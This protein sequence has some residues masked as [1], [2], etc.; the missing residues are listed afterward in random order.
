M[1]ERMYA[2]RA[3]PLWIAGQRLLILHDTVEVLDPRTG[4]KHVL[5][6]VPA[7]S[8]GIASS[9]G[10]RV[11]I[12]G[13]GGEL[14]VLD[15]ATLAFTPMWAGHRV[16][17]IQ[18][19]PDGS[20]LAAGDGER[21]VVLDAAGKQ[22][23]ERAGG[24]NM[25]ASTQDRLALFDAKA[26]HVLELDVAPAPAW[27]DYPIPL[28]PHGVM[29]AAHYRADALQVF[30]SASVFHFAD[31]ALQSSTPLDELDAAL[32]PDLADGIDVMP[33]RDGNLH[34]YGRGVDG[35][36]PLP[37]AMAN[38]H[39]AG[40]HGQTR[41]VAA[42]TGLVLIFDLADLIP[43]R[44]P[45]HG[46][47]EAQFIDDDTLL[48]WPDDVTTFNFYDLVTGG[49]TPLVHDAVPFTRALS[50][51]PKT[52]R[53]L[54]AEPHARDRQVLLSIQKG[55]PNDV[56][57]LAGAERLLARTTPTGLIAAHDNDPRVLYSE[58]DAQFR[59][60]AKVDG[61]VQSL[62]TFGHDR[63]AALGRS[64]ELVRGTTAGGPLERIHV[65]VDA[66]SFLGIDR[67]EHVIVAV[68]AHLFVWDTTLHPLVELPRAAAALY[69]VPSGLVAILD[70][71]AA[72][73]VTAE[74]KPV[75]HD[76]VVASQ[77]APIVGGE[78]SWLASP[79]NAGALAIV[80]LP[81]LARWTL[82]PQPSSSMN[83]LI[84]APTKRRLAQGVST[85]IL[86]Y[87]LVEAKGDLSAW[88]D[89]RTNAYE[90]PDG[91]VS[92]PWLRP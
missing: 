36:V 35:H 88:L 8:Y 91:F 82:P 39:L 80:E 41:F 25:V 3:Y 16:T 59:E 14:G 51:D 15:A 17:Q 13:T 70:N 58:H 74:A 92:W 85:G 63:F 44:I 40:R 28:G 76:L 75:V 73:Y 34:F 23:A 1:Y 56:K 2:K 27:H 53:M 83:F 65:D 66:N 31:H 64:G 38:P 10:A 72:V 48:M 57:T 68:G 71:N 7:A 42:A 21:I 19:A 47:L 55:H 29:I 49:K 50:G 6:S 87:D 86:V 5:P 33:A 77:S 84:A 11:A 90:N 78:G 69:A 18:Y 4:A 62:M 46:E 26:Q 12:Q 89:D 54:L 81:S 61:G 24:L 43:K 52:G 79:G 45:K 20:W 30:T 67:D 22:I 32:A 9:D 37:V 60:L